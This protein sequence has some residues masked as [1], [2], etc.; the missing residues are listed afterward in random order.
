VGEGFN[1]SSA[2]IT[3]A[4]GWILFIFERQGFALA[5]AVSHSPQVIISASKG[6]L[7]GLTPSQGGH[8]SQEIK[9]AFV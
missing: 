7:C 1:F 9:L 5:F 3:G 4:L 2:R 8:E 6:N